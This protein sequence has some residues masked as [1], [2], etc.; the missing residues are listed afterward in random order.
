[1]HCLVSIN[2]NLFFLSHVGDGINMV[3][4]AGISAVS[5]VASSAVILFLVI[6]VYVCQK[7]KKRKDFN[8]GKYL[9]VHCINSK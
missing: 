6:T 8:I 7:K 9:G 4:I 5:A 1:M 2:N 3:Y